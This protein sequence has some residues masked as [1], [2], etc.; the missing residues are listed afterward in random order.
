MASGQYLLQ[1][2]GPVRNTLNDFVQI[3]VVLGTARRVF[4]FLDTPRELDDA[5]GRS[6]DVS[7]GELQVENVEFSYGDEDVLHRVSVWRLAR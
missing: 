5:A 1:V 3:Q 4:G 7:R 6:L 2:G